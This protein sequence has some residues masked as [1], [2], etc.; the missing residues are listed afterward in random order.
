MQ[1]GCGSAF[2]DTQQPCDFFVAQIL[3]NIKI[4]DRTV[5]A[6]K[7]CY[8]FLD[9]LL[10]DSGKKRSFIIFLLG[11]VLKDGY[12]VQGAPLPEP[13]DC[14]VGRDAVHPGLQASRLVR[15]EPV[16]IVNDLDETV[17][18]DVFGLLP[19]RNVSPDGRY[20]GWGATLIE[21][22]E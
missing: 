14:F 15:F 8:R 22:L 1:L 12:E 6:W 7:L 19:V 10:A 18:Q 16:Q 4:Q 20:Q 9:T 5:S 17:L 3:K 13:R 11:K 2:A 21:L